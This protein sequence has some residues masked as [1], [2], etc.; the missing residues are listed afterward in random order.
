MNKTER[1]IQQIINSGLLPLYYHESKDL[2]ISILKALYQSGIRIIEYTNR[3]ENALVNFAALRTI[4]SQEM[5][6]LLLGIGT[7]KTAK[8]AKEFIDL[9]ADFIVSPIVSAEVA[10]IVL[11]HNLAWIPGCLTPTEIHQA[12]VYGARLVKIFPGNLVGSSYVQSIKDIFPDLL[13]M[14]TGGVE[15]EEQNLKS[16]FDAGVSAVGM[17]SKLLKTNV[18]EENNFEA[19]SEY[20]TK[21]T[22]LIQSCKHS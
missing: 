20:I 9:G 5:P 8:I 11:E 10:K 17:G 22:I 12:Q 1:V 2:S 6:D 13:F 18:I 3:G 21:V 14:P 15:P 7:V 16:W 4:A 19:L